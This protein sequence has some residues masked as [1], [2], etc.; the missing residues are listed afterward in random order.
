MPPDVNEP[1]STRRD[2][3]FELFQRERAEQLAG[4]IHIGSPT[5]QRCIDEGL[6][7]SHIELPVVRALLFRCCEAACQIEVEIDALFI[8]HSGLDLSCHLVG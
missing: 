7:W 3:Q 4:A 5:A 1:V 8:G 2:L 6:F